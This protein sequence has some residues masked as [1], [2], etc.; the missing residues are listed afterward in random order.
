MDF[1]VFFSSTLLNGRKQ[2]IFDA[3][4]III[5]GI[6]LV[7]SKWIF[8]AVVYDVLNIKKEKNVDK[9][10]CRKEYEMCQL[11]NNNWFP[12]EY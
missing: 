3:H 5:E 10:E 11:R 4:E 9:S 7:K 8:H 1:E 2:K 6:R 12:V